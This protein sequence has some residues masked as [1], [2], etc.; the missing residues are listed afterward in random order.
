MFAM[1]GTRGEGSRWRSAGALALVAL[2]SLAAHAARAQAPVYPIGLAGPPIDPQEPLLA[3]GPR[4]GTLPLLAPRFTLVVS[5]AHAPLHYEIAGERSVE[6]EDVVTASLGA[7]LGFGPADLGV[8]MPVHLAVLGTADGAPLQATAPG[9]L[10]VV[11]RVAP[12]P[13]GRIP[14]A[15]VLSVPVSIPTGDE[16]RYGGRA[17]FVAE[18][19]L[20]V[21]FRAGPLAVAV[22]PG[23]RAQGSGTLPGLGDLGTLRVALGVE[24]GPDHGVSVRPELGFDGLLPLAEPE[25]ASGEVVG[26]AAIRPVAGLAI[27]AHGAVGLGPLPGVA[28]GRLLVG[29]SWEGLG[30]RGPRDLDGDGVQGSRDACPEVPEDRDGYQDADGCPD[31]DNDGDGVLDPSDACPAQPGPAHG[32]GC[33]GGGIDLDGDRIVDDACPVEP[34]DRDGFEDGDGCPD[35]DNDGDRIPDHRDACPGQAEDGA[36]AAPDDGCPQ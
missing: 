32:S 5:G 14:L 1:V 36:G 21:R 25:L 10:V 6:I 18:P 24:L 31:A 19:R 7:A 8:L 11:P 17:G 12:I 30:L 29:V 23:V 13:A 28:S 34:E 27:A 15:V 33:P 22:R 3:P 9:D 35:P 26:G 4:L 20:G 16:A 2:L